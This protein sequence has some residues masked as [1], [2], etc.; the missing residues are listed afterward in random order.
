MQ[1]TF[2][3]FGVPG[4]QMAQVSLHRVGMPKVFM[5]RVGNS[6]ILAPFR[7]YAKKLLGS[8]SSASDLNKKAPD[9]MQ[10]GLH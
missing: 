3:G 7:P 9:L 2:G 1:K 8:L 5:H 6:S 4:G 10:T